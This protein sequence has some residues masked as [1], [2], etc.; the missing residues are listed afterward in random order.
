MSGLGFTEEQIH[1]YSRHIILKEVGGAGQKKL[2]SSSALVVGA[3][4]LGSPVLL[5]LAAAGVG[6]LGIADG[7]LVELSNLQRQVI[8][9]TQDIGKSKV[10]SAQEAIRDINPDCKVDVFPEHLNTTN[11][12]DYEAVAPA[13]NGVFETL[14]AVAKLVLTELKKGG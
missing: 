8:H 2:L 7:D 12:P 14:K 1:R 11:I 5:Y 13:G 10:L 3:G 6:R 4:G 9:K